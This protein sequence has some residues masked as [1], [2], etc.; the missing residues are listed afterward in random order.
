MLESDSIPLSFLLTFV[1][2]KVKIEQPDISEDIYNKV[3]SEII[4][5]ESDRRDR[6][7]AKAILINTFSD[8][9][10]FESQMA[11]AVWNQLNE[12]GFPEG[13]VFH[14][15]VWE[16]LP[17]PTD[18]NFKNLHYKYLKEPKFIRSVSGGT[19]QE[20]LRLITP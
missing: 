12:N 18:I 13:T 17:H 14:I 4:S 10:K 20:Y 7:I 9:G 8:F 16:E 15:R 3:I 19:N 5:Q 6:G 1:D 2:I 11:R